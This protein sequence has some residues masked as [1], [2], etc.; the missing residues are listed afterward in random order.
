MLGLALEALAQL[1]VLAWPRPTGQVF[2]WQ[3]RIITQPS[4]ISG[5]V[6]KP[7]SSAPSIA[8]DHHVAAR[9]HLAVDLDEDARA[10]VVPQQRLLR[11]GEADL[12]GDAACWI[13]ACGEAPVPPS[14]PAITTWS[15]FALATPAAIVPT[16]D[17]GHELHRH[18]R[19]RIGA[20]Q[21]VDQ[22]LEVLD[23]VDVV[24]RRRRDQ[25]HARRRVAQA[26]DVAV[27]LVAGELAALAGLG[28]LRDLDL[29]LVGVGEV[30]HGHAEAPG[31]HL[32]DRR[33]PLVLEARRVL[34]ALAGV[35]LAA[36]AVHAHG[37]RLVGLGRER[38]EAHAAGLEAAHDVDRRLHL[39]ER[40]RVEVVA[41]AQQ[42]AQRR[43]RG[44]HVVH[45]AGE[46]LVGLGAVARSRA[47]CWSAR[48][49][50]R[51]PA[52]E[53]P[54]A[55]PGVDAADGSSSDV[56]PRVGAGVAVERLARRAPRAPRR[57][58]ATRCP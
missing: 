18:P 38:A 56:R 26:G 53:H 16:P 14:W 31:R 13:D 37:E 47:A 32:L 58:C 45:V 20:A 8:A 6:E 17:L 24:V 35:R 55:A 7:N 4:A 30:V 19:A 25:A 42:A 41:E 51:V 27:H 57:R 48:D 9:A 46:A 22:L 15:A 33:A 11:L 34:A 2:R 40:D 43:A 3:T 1:R 44:G 39:V 50:L 21:V 29:E 12:P 52:V 28:A 54:A 36:E 23:R 10:K 49:R 5:A